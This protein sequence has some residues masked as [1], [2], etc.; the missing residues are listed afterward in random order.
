MDTSLE[1]FSRAFL[2]SAL[3][4]RALVGFLVLVLV[5]VSFGSLAPPVNSSAF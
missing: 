1:W 3:V 4:S 5:V 2:V